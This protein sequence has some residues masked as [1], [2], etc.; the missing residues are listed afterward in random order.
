M[1]DSYGE[2]NREM[3]KDTADEAGMTLRLSSTIFE[4]GGDAESNNDPERPIDPGKLLPDRESADQFST[5]PRKKYRFIRGLGRGGMKMVLQ[6]RDLDATRDVAMAVLPDAAVCSREDISRFVQ[7]A[8]LTASL[9]HPNIVP[10]HDIGV[11]AS[12]APYFTMKLLRGRT[13]ASLIAKLASGD[14][15][16]TADYQINRLLRIFLK[17]CYGVAFAHSRGVIHL[18][19]KPENIQIGDFGEVLIMDWGLAKIVDSPDSA[20]GMQTGKAAPEDGLKTLDGI[21]KGTPGYMAPEQAAGWNDRKDRRTD[22]YALGAILYAMMTLKDPL[23]EKSVKERIDA[24]VEGRIIPPRERAPEREIPAAVEAVILKAMSLR[25]EDRYQSVRELRNE[26]NAFIGGYAT[27]AEKASVAKKTMLFM[28]RHAILSTVLGAAMLLAFAGTA[29]MIRNG[30]RG[31]AGWQ[32]SAVFSFEPGKDAGLYHAADPLNRT[33]RKP[34]LTADRTLILNS[35]EWLRLDQKAQENIRIDLTWQAGAPA[36]PLE[37]FV[38]TGEAPL[39]SDGAM[40]PGY[41]FRLGAQ[42]GYDWILRIDPGGT[43]VPLAAAPSFLVPGEN[44]VSV[45]VFDG[46]L[47]AADGSGTVRLEAEDV[48]LVPPP[49][50]GCVSGIRPLTG[51][52]EITSMKI[53]VQAIPEPMTPLFRSIVLTEAG[54]YRQAWNQCLAAADLSRGEPVEDDALL[55]AYR[56]AAFQLPDE[57]LRNE[58]L[59]RIRSQPVFSRKAHLEE[60]KA[61]ALWRQGEYSRAFAAVDRIMAGDPENAILRKILTLP[62][63]E[64]PEQAAEELLKRL[65]RMRG[66]EWLDLSGLGL[67]SLKPLRKLRLKWLNCSRNRLRDLAGTENMP[68]KYL[69]CRGNP[70]MTDLP[71][72]WRKKT[73]DILLFDKMTDK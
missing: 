2:I 20:D 40:P 49:E 9:E 14:P 8:R 73:P 18:D 64:L 44:S 42:D 39:K 55:R 68:L 52:A 31:F 43:A 71:A 47:Q 54:L 28:R 35:G 29:Y 25:P 60:L 56:L 53:S 7:E 59:G 24:T 16:F 12:G 21:M 1:A 45:S 23:A 38:R 13:L 32:G 63:K 27:V 17:I 41:C 65:G 22:I 48:I 30:N 6:V 4:E 67:R 37:I 15:E 11:D 72:E 70:E 34:R 57:K 61:L 36:R 3:S 69:D 51:P 50:T 62:R 26:V 66:A 19:L 10:V 46:K 58:I 5:E 33:G